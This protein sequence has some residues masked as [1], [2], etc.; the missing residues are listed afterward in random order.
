MLF[1]L[2]LKIIFFSAAVDGGK[3]VLPL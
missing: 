1:C 2:V 3:N